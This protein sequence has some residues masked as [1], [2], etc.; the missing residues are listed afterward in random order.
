MVGWKWVG[1]RDVRCERP[2]A[3]SRAPRRGAQLD[4]TGSH[5][6]RQIECQNRF[7]PVTTDHQF[8]NSAASPRPRPV[9]QAAITRT[10]PAAAQINDVQDIIRPQ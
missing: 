1:R 6:A 9:N 3:R 5:V 2:G 7:N 8:L 4:R 10:A